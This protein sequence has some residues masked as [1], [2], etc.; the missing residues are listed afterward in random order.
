[1]SIYLIVHGGC[2]GGWY[3]RQTAQILKAQ[4]HEVFT[5]TLTGLG[6]RAH[7]ANPNIDLNTHIQD[8]IGVLECE[9]LT[10]II[11][12]GHS[13][14]SFVTTGV[15]EQVPHR[16]SWLVYLD[17]PPPK[18]GQS[19][20][21]LLGPEVSTGLYKL[22]KEKGDGWRLPMIPG[23]PRW[24]PHPLKPCIEP[25][26]INN[27]ATQKVPH[28]FIH[29]TAR[30]TG[31]LMAAFWPRIDKA[32]EEAK[33]QGWWYRSIPTDHT[34]NLSAPQQLAEVLLELA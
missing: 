27:P 23:P 26:S 21:D 29:C 17:A 2:G 30:T 14:G 9:D 18:D 28:A 4:G 5:P 33:R 3:Y 8:I 34:P 6:E 31:Y 15:A 12:V 22:A 1:M 16:L 11:L 25:I 7:L 13:S 20:F 10:Q 19:W 24:Q 32:A